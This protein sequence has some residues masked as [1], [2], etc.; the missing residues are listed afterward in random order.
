MAMERWIEGQRLKG[1]NA[2]VEEGN[3]LLVKYGEINLSSVATP[4]VH[5]SDKEQTGDT[6]RKVSAEYKKSPLTP[7]IVNT[8]WK[9]LWAEWGK[10]VNL[11][12]KVPSC[13]RTSEELSQLQ[14][15]NRAVL[16]IPDN[17]NLVMLGKIFPQM[18]SWAVQ[19]GTTV[20]D[21][22]SKGGSID[23]E[24]DLD[25]P[26]RNTTESQARDLIKSQGRDGQR[27]KTYI[28]GS[29][30]SKLLTGHYFDEKTWSRLPGSRSGG[31]MVDAY[32]YSDGHLRVYSFL[33]PRGQYPG[34]GFRSE[35]V[36]RA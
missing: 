7:E 35:G 13:D 30:F 10:R 23:I 33:F 8:T 19:E 12:F 26:N 15:E 25:S 16:F 36:K 17:V 22:Q 14:K 11:T 21:E 2:A 31:G 5:K 9:T 3:K 20:A 4:N 32:F 28:I 27:L 1:N 18:R 34:L 6:I 24:M 29:Q